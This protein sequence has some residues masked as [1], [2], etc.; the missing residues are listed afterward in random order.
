MIEINKKE[1]INWL[2]VIITISIG[3]ICLI[4][5]SYIFSLFLLLNYYL[6]FI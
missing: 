5:F 6:S 2:K 3:Y 1:K 4:I